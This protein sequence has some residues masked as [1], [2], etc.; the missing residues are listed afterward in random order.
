M[1]NVHNSLYNFLIKIKKKNTER[2][3]AHLVSADHICIYIFTL[4]KGNVKYILHLTGRS[5]FT[6][7]FMH[8]KQFSSNIKILFTK[9]IVSNYKS[10]LKATAQVRKSE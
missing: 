5:I 1:L 6:G 2:S 7:Y 8:T 3:Y 10:S 9:C 4:Y